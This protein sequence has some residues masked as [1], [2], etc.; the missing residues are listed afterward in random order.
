[1]KIESLHIGLKVKHPQYGVGVVKGISERA[2]EVKFD[3]A[4]RTVDPEISGLQPAEPTVTLREL[5]VPLQTLLSQAIEATLMRMGWEKPEAVVTELGARWHKGKMVMHPADPT[6]QTKEVP[7]EVFFHKIVG[8]RNQMRVLE[9]KING[10]PLLSDADK[11]EMQQ[12]VTRCYG[13]MTTFNVLFAQKG[14]E[15]R[16]SS[17]GG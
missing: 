15:F 11:T 2:A 1:M 8:M 14:S 17:Q 7:M 12:Y 10:H 16:G 13:S 3:D 4:L 9:Q 6:L 5:D